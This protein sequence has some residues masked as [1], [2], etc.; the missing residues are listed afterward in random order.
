MAELSIIPEL[1]RQLDRLQVVA[2]A[3]DRA[4]LRLRHPTIDP[5]AVPGEVI[6]ATLYELEAALAALGEDELEG[7]PATGPLWQAGSSIVQEWDDERAC[8]APSA[9]GLSR[10]DRSTLRDA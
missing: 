5:E 7:V 2:Q 10:A 8:V 4:R 9:Q 6:V 1:I 3:A